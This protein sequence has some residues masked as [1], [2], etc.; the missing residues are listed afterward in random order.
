MQVSNN[1]DLAYD[2]EPQTGLAAGNLPVRNKAGDN[3]DS[4]SQPIISQARSAINRIESSSPATYS[5]QDGY[6][7]WTEVFRIRLQVIK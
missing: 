3:E 6:K 4:R 1:D 5:K 2:P 7:D